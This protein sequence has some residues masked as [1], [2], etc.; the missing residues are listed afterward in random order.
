MRTLPEYFHERS[1][2]TVRRPWA[3]LAALVL[4]GFL[5]PVSGLSQKLDLPDPLALPGQDEAPKS[6]N[7]P[8]SSNSSGL[9]LVEP[10]VRDGEFKGTVRNESQT[11][12]S[13]TIMSITAQK[14]AGDPILWTFTFELG[15]MPPGG[16][17]PVSAP[18]PKDLEIPGY[19]DVSFK[20]TV[21]EAP[22]AS[23]ESRKKKS[24]PRSRID[25][26]K[27][28]DGSIKLQAK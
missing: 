8:E 3:I 4:A 7:A 9:L 14:K 18:Y 17:K 16:E 24:A 22:M 21:G 23:P 19:L 28:S 26:E 1:L 6:E 13:G 11:F 2:R 15:D 25:I 20:A 10:V 27:K 5:F 12:W